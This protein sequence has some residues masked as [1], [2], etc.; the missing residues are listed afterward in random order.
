M[1]L[2]VHPKMA[3][4]C[5]TVAPLS[6]ARVA[7]IAVTV[8][9]AA[10]GPS[11]Q[12]GTATGDTSVGTDR[13]F[14]GVTSVRGSGFDDSLSGSNN[15]ANTAEQF[16]GGAGNDT[17]DGRGGFDR[18]QYSSFVD[19]TTTGGVTVSLA[20]GTAT[21]DASVGTDTLRSVEAVRGS[22]FADIYDARDFA[23]GSPNA[24]SA[25][26][27][28]NGAAFNE[29][30]GMSGNDTIVGNGN[31]RISYQNATGGVTVNL[32][33]PD[34]SQTYLTLTQTG[35]TT[36]DSSVGTD[37]IYR[38]SSRTSKRSPLSATPTTR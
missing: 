24:G 16:N 23:A 13:F 36:G 37:R 31:T 11:G 7:A 35:I 10:S 38:S 2:P 26:V 34:A 5:A 6:A 15:A 22:N 8:D 28:A 21:G 30:E 3:L 17:I 9:L 29:F 32:S 4:S 18:V 12:T 25:G 1:A 14:G 27:N 20:A 19:D 33:S